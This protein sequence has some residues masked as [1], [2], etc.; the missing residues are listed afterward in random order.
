LT[1]LPTCIHQVRE[2]LAAA[3]MLAVIPASAK[4]G[5]GGGGGGEKAMAI[6]RA[7]EPLRVAA[8]TMWFD[9]VRD[10]T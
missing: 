4:R 5:G 1:Y 3:E 6:A 9:G 7:S 10:A 8:M 2:R